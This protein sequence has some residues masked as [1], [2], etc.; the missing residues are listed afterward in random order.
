MTARVIPL[1]R[2][3]PSRPIVEI[4]VDIAETAVDLTLCCDDE[5]GVITDRQNAAA[6]ITA[7]LDRMTRLR[8]ELAEVGR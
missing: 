8:D 3:R 2:S 4:A 6:K 1:A 5:I 7:Y